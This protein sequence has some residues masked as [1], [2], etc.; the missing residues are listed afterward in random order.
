MKRFLCT[1]A[2]AE[3]AKVKE[4]CLSMGLTA[5]SYDNRR[6]V[7]REQERAERALRASLVPSREFISKVT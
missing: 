5:L 6:C 2:E 7:T 4:P 3:K 1:A